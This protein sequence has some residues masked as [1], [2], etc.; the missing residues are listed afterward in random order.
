MDSLLALLKKKSTGQGSFALEN[1]KCDFFISDFD[2]PLLYTFAPFGEASADTISWGFEFGKNLDVNVIAIS[3]VSNESWYQDPELYELALNL[4]KLANFSEILGYGGS[5]GGFGVSVYSNILKIDRLLLLNPFSTLDPN[6][7]PEETRF[8]WYQR[9]LEWDSRFNDGAITCSKG[10]VVYDPLFKLDALQA[11]RFK[12]FKLVKLHGVGHQIP[13]HLNKLG[14][15]KRLVIDFLNNGSD[16]AWFYKASRN[17]RFY[18]GYFAW[19]QSQEN[20]HLTQRRKATITKC[21]HSLKKLIS[22]KP[23]VDSVTGKDID[24]IR[25]L[26]LDNESKDLMKAKMLME[27][28]LKLRPEGEFL[29]MKVS[30][31]N[32][33]LDGPDL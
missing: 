20:I 22:S 23:G 18:P 1:I 16:F 25:D 15:L 13:M 11:K 17:R 28:A 4:G 12:D 10:V 21:Q 19:M 9:N 26:A 2:K 8:R 31:Y 3:L 5:M 7:I 6:I 32:K 29:K 30:S 24:F 14:L 33:R 27:I